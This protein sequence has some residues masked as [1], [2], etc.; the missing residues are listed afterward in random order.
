MGQVRGQLRHEFVDNVAEPLIAVVPVG[1]GR[2]DGRQQRLDNAMLGLERIRQCHSVGLSSHVDAQRGPQ[3]VIFGLVVDQQELLEQLP[4]KRGLQQLARVAVPL[5]RDPRDLHEFPA[6]RVVH[7]EHHAHVELE[8]HGSS[9]IRP[10]P[11]NDTQSYLRSSLKR[12]SVCLVS[13][14]RSRIGCRA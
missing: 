6:Q 5:A 13:K 9:S 10:L 12:S 4:P 8:I 7:R 11:H 3:G 14:C 1:R 2:V